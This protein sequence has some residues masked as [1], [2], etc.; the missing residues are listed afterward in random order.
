[1]TP[2]IMYQTQQTQMMQNEILQEIRRHLLTLFNGEKIKVVENS[3]RIFEQTILS[4]RTLPVVA[5]KMY[6]R[7]DNMIATCVGAPH[8]LT[9]PATKEVV[10]DATRGTVRINRTPR[11]VHRT[12]RDGSTPGDTSISIRSIWANSPFFIGNFTVSPTCV[13]NGSL[14]VRNKLQ[15]TSPDKI[16]SAQKLDTDVDIKLHDYRDYA[17]ISAR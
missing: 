12:G 4:N 3:N 15:S 9:M 13:L 14:Q 11:N 1:M 10:S 17:S 2:N 6:P 8:T 7:I 16:S 5:K